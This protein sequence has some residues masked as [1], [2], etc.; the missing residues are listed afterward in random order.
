ML[1]APPFFV[2][3]EHA[4]RDG[5]LAE[6]AVEVL[7]VRWS[8]WRSFS[9]SSSRSRVCL[10]SASASARSCRC[11]A[12][13]SSN[14]FRRAAVFSAA[15]T[16]LMRLCTA[17]MKPQMP[18]RWRRRARASTCRARLL[19]SRA[20]VR[21]FAC[22][23]SWLPPRSLKGQ[24]GWQLTSVFLAAALSETSRTSRATSAP[25]AAADT[26]ACRCN[27][28][29]PQPN[30]GSNASTMLA[31]QFGD[32]AVFLD[33]RRRAKRKRSSV[34]AGEFISVISCIPPHRYSC[35]FRLHRAVAVQVRT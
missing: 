9:A 3:G 24:R 23:E 11:R 30:C 6:I 14:S 8:A 7:V 28:T 21:A 10:M 12:F 5:V 25:A 17:S 26:D 4:L 19:A 20:C 35:R 34:A 32:R 2:L 16:G 29:T 27:S 13:I 31:L 15:A 1:L 18:M 33:P 22:L